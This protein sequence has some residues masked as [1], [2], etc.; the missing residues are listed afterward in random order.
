M[1]ALFFILI[2]SW[3]N[4]IA[5]IILVAISYLSISSSVISIIIY[6]A[7]ALFIVSIANTKCIWE[8]V[9]VQIVVVVIMIIIFRL[10]W[11]IYCLTCFEAIIF[12]NLAPF[13]YIWKTS[14]AHINFIGTVLIQSIIDNIKIIFAVIMRVIIPLL[15][16]ARIYLIVAVLLL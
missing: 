11:I 10:L 14:S 8:I 16:I 9:K 13:L 1:S 6:T 7:I 5:A 2:N 12:T 15:K 4:S 3:A